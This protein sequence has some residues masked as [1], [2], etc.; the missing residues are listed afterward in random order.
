MKKYSK[1]DLNEYLKNDVVLDKLNQNPEDSSFASHKW[2]L[3]IPAKRMI[4]NDV[5]GDILK[6]KGKK[7]LDVG[8][9]FCSLSRDIIKDNQYTLLD[10]MAHDDHQQIIDIEKKLGDF[11]TNA[12]WYDFVPSEQYDY[13]IANDLFPNVDQRLDA[14]VKKF[15]P[16]AKKLIITI[17]CYDKDRFYK[18]KRIDAPEILTIQ[19]W[20]SA[21]TFH[22]LKNY[23]NIDLKDEQLEQSS[24]FDN[25]RVVYKVVT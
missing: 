22:I 23:V 8:G 7:I 10:I 18:V 11:W 2:L 21:M 19:A 13:I 24:I 9:G 15:K 17:S 20:N 16:F 3:D 14:F 4:Y 25:G 5:Y 12:D 6:E 1:E